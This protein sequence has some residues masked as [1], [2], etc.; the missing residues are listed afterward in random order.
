MKIH[1]DKIT[2]SDIQ[3][4]MRKCVTAGTM[5]ATVVL[6]WADSKGSRKRAHGI[7]FSLGTTDG[8]TFVPTGLEDWYRDYL[9][10][11]AD[12]AS[13]AARRAGRRHVRNTDRAH[14][15]GNTRSATYMEWGAVIWA[16]FTVDPDAIIGTYD[17]RMRFVWDTMVSPRTM[18]LVYSDSDWARR[19]WDGRTMEWL[20]GQ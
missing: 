4:S 17:G 14:Q 13:K 5:A 11:P 15:T 18:D 9:G 6:D 3:E 16:L 1:S 12:V 2:V 20:T 7:D 10:V 8:T 19:S